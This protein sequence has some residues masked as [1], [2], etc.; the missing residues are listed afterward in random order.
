MRAKLFAP[1]AVVVIALLV[2]LWIAHPRQPRQ[3][4]KDEHEEKADTLTSGPT[5][6]R[7]S[8]CR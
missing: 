6:T 2:G 5:S 7:T 3:R 1:Q 4:D 8:T